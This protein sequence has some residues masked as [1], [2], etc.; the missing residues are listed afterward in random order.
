M[1]CSSY[2][3]FLGPT[4]SPPS[5][6]AQLSARGGGEV[7]YQ[8]LDQDRKPGTGKLESPNLCYYN[9]TVEDCNDW[10]NETA[11]EK[12]FPRDSGYYGHKKYIGTQYSAFTWSV[13]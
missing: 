3:G 5:A 4:P 2:I 8:L 6:P 7:Y 13:Y 10:L 9:N 12:T 1:R 11:A